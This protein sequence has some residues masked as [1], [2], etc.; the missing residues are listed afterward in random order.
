MNRE[1]ESVHG[2]QS[3]KTDVLDTNLD[4]MFATS[5]DESFVEKEYEKDG[6][7]SDEEESG[8]KKKPAAKSKNVSIPYDCG[9]CPFF[10]MPSL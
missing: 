7:W 2:S 1:G 3:R 5:E 9:M 6:S 4:E 10:F 8:A